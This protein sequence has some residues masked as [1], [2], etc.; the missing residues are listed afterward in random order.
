ALAYGLWGVPRFTK[1]LDINVFAAGER[2]RTVFAVLRELGC[3]VDEAVAMQEAE[4]DGLMVFHLGTLRIDVFTA[5]IEFCRQAEDRRVLRRVGGSQAW[6]LS[7]EVLAVFK[8][9]F[10]RAK[11]VVDLERL[12]VVQGPRLDVAWVRAQLVTVVGEDDERVRRWDAL[13]AA[14]KP[15]R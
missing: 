5:S 15:T 1:D 10:F 6:F 4:R 7:A 2:L 13:V 3:T 14:A 11:D 9:L 12:L 8:L